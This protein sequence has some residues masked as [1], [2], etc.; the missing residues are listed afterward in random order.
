[1]NQNNPVIAAIEVKSVQRRRKINIANAQT[2]AKGP[3]K[4]NQT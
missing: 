3:E 4:P 1:V 2:I